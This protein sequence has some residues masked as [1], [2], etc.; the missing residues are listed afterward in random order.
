MNDEI[1]EFWADPKQRA[2][3]AYLASIGHVC[4]QWSLLELT[5]LP[6]LYAIEDVPAEK[7]DLLFGHL[8]LLPQIGMAISLADNQ[9]MPGKV[10]TE[11]KAIKKELQDGV[12]ERRNQAVHEAHADTD[13]LGTFNL[14]MARW[15]GPKKLQAVSLE[16][17]IKLTEDIHALQRRM[18]GVFE[19]IG[20]WKFDSRQPDTAAE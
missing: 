13:T 14:R 6:V 20:R 15:R 3:T 19:Q 4:L 8:D 10:I 17:L 11:L 16:D 1:S 9:R 5:T 18:Y 2:K 7:G 12:R